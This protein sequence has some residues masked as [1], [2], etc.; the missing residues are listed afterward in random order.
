M[1]SLRVISKH[2]ELYREVCS[3]EKVYSSQYKIL[4]QNFTR[5]D[6]KTLSVS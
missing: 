2:E 1:T 4:Y 5:T 3:N 6:K